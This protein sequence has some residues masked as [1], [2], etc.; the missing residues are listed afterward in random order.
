MGLTAP[1]LALATLL[2]S[3]TSFTV[4]NG[5]IVDDLGRRTVFHGVNGA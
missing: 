4:N 5:M 2:A 1:L 3:A